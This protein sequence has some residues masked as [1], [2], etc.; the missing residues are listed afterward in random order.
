VGATMRARWH[1]LDLRNI[2]VGC[3]LG[4]LV[5][6]QLGVLRLERALLRFSQL[7]R[8]RK[9]ARLEIGRLSR[10][11]LSPGSWSCMSDMFHEWMRVCTN[12]LEL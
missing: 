4:G 12:Q 11:R 10:E 7:T 8:G 5:D 3:S 9:T 1:V 6:G 2:I